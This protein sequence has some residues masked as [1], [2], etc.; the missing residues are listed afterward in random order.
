MAAHTRYIY[1]YVF[2][3]LCIHENSTIFHILML[4]FLNFYCFKI[5]IFTFFRIQF[6]LRGIHGAETHTHTGM[7]STHAQHRAED[8]HGKPI[9]TSVCARMLH[10][11]PILVYFFFFHFYNGMFRLPTYPHLRTP[12][13][14][15]I[16]HMEIGL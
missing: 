16:V 2:Q 10:T 15:N 1:I 7:C 5:Y 6:F 4:P 8:H 3:P 14:G 9:S 11:Q 13:P 12:T